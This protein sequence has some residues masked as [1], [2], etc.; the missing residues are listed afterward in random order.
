MGC[1]M[2]APYTEIPGSEPRPSAPV[3]GTSL[4]YSAHFE[5]SFLFYIWMSGVLG[6][7]R[8]TLFGLRHQDEYMP[9]TL[10]LWSSCVGQKDQQK[11]LAGTQ[12]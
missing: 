11:V 8:I 4:S 7:E 10:V 9:G 1:E 12:L 6:A 3:T 5:V 2:C